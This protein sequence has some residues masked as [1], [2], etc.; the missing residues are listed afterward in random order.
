MPRF[1]LSRPAAPASACLAAAVCLVLGSAPARGQVVPPLANDPLA[2][3]QQYDPRNPPRFQKSNRAPYTQAPGTAVFAPAAGAGRTG[4][5]SSNSRK[6]QAARPARPGVSP[7]RAPALTPSAPPVSPYQKPAPPLGAYAQAPGTPPPET[8][9]GPIRKPPPKRKAHVELAD[10]YEPLGIHAGAFMLYPAVEL[11]GGYDTNPGRSSSDPQGAKLYTVAPELRAQ[12]NWSR[13]ELKADL[14]GSYTGYSPDETPTLSRP[15]VNGKV[16]GRVDVT[17]ATRIDLGGRLLVSSDNPGSPNLQAGLSKLPIFTTYGGSAGLGQ[18][19]NRF[20]VS[21]KGD[22]ERTVYQDSQLTDGTSASNEDRNYNQ[23]GGRLRGGYELS[24]G[25]MPFV[26][27]GADTRKHDLETDPYGYQR[28]SKGQ[29]VSV[30][31]T[32]ELSRL[33]TGETS[34]GYMQ[35]TYDDPRLDKIAGL[36]G[37]ASLVWT[38]SALTTVKFTAASSIGESTVPG[39]SGTLYRDLGLQVDH[40]FRR[41]LIG[42]VKVGFGNDDYVGLDRNDTRYSA[43]AGLTYKLDRALQLKGEFRQQWLRSNVTGVDYTASIFLIGLRWQQ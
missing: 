15:Y 35:R 1:R 5:D 31:S 4:F 14:R 36:M 17:R 25:L 41:W 24:P 39:V 6:K 29:T 21:I 42:S 9:T 33:L 26:E 13:H 28:N 34:I 40:A 27:V 18:R 16:D 30:G 10:P 43:G 32:F 11:L 23:Y 3:K 2:P 7:A 37:N 38:A 19:F 12:S 22:V 8:T 20:D